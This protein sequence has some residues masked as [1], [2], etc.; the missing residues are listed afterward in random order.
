MNSIIA[1]TGN[2]GR[3]VAYV[4]LRKGDRVIINAR[5]EKRL[6]DAQEFLK[7]YGNL[8]YH[9]SDL[10]TEQGVEDFFNSSVKE[11]ESIDNLIITLGGYAMD[12]IEN[13]E[14]LDEMLDG[15]LKI[16]LNLVR[17]FSKIAHAGSTIT[18]VSSIQ[19]QYTRD[20]NSLSY[21]IAKNALNKLIEVSAANL[22]V[23]GIRVNGV[24]VSMIESGFAPGRDWTSRDLGDPLTPPEGIAEVIAFLT[25]PE[26][27]CIDG[28]VIPVDSGSRFSN[29]DRA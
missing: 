7:E 25:R 27:Q 1:G 8:K 5:S 20:W 22:L 11:L 15:H 2:L 19:A 14:H 9:V 29:Q 16:P 3:A 21:L 6:V 12:S 23:K 28:A 26:S 4:L 24:A 10:S 18:M 17:R 13:P